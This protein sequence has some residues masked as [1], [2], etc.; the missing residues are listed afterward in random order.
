MLQKTLPDA[1]C[2]CHLDDSL[3][4]RCDAWRQR[5][6]LL[7]RSDDSSDWGCSPMSRSTMVGPHPLRTAQFK[8]RRHSELL[9]TSVGPTTC[10]QAPS[11]LL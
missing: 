2:R 7:A 5:M 9:P 10:R 11:T 6:V 3:C 1:S 8:S 4:S